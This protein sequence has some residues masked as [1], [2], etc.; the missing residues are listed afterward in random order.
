MG[1]HLAHGGD[2]FL[3]GFRQHLVH[4]RKRP[5]GADAGHHILALGVDEE[6]AI[7][8]LRAGRGVPGE[9]HAGGGVVATVPEDHL[10]DIDSRAQVGGDVVRAAV[11]LSPGVLPGTEHG[12]HGPVQLLDRIGC[13][14]TTQVIVADLLEGADELLEVIRAK[15]GVEFDAT[16]A[17]QLGQGVLVG[18]CR[19]ALDYFAVHLD[20]TPVAVPGKTLIAGLLGDGRHRIIGDTKIEDGVHHPGHG[21]H[22]TGADRDQQGFLR[23]AELASCAFFQPGQAGVDLAGQSIRPLTAPL[24]G[25]HARRGG[26]GEGVGDRNPDPG[27]LSDARPLSPE[28]VPHARVTFREVVDVALLA[29]SR[30][31]PLIVATDLPSHPPP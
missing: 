12:V 24:H 17:F 3:I 5:R 30:L 21:E 14:F 9:A 4:L 25:L 26:D 22:S 10:H 28:Q 7:E 1:L 19:D 16:L 31:S 8:F 2:E 23:P 18:V 11:H 15:I 13:P 27:H 20:E 29:H 6:L